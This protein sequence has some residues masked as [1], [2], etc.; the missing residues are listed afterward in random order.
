LDA[1][2]LH[3][4]ALIK[5]DSPCRN[6]LQTSCTERV[7]RLLLLALVI[8]FKNATYS[9]P[10][11][12]LSEWPSFGWLLVSKQS[13]RL[14]LHNLH[15]AGLL[16]LLLTGEVRA[17]STASKRS[18]R[19]LV[20]EGW[21]ILSTNIVHNRHSFLLARIVLGELNITLRDAERR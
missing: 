5:Q 18:R 21:L 17:D 20:V 16:L 13:R 9:R 12:R 4:V 6:R 7:R 14:F 11:S 2:L 1:W 8:A 19:G 3:G 15:K 10:L